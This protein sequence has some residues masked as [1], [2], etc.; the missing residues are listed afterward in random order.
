[1]IGKRRFAALGADE[2]YVRHALGPLPFGGPV[3]TR[4]RQYWNGNDAGA[5][6]AARGRIV[7][8]GS[9]ERGHERVGEGA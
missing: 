7:W 5:G 1:M 3:F 8:S 4:G 9:V 2:G 6:T